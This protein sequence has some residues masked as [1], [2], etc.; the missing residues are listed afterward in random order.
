ML[1]LVLFTKLGLIRIPFLSSRGAQLFF[2][3]FPRT[4][5]CRISVQNFDSILQRLHT[6]PPRSLLPCPNVR[7]IRIRRKPYV[8]ELTTN[9][10]GEKPVASFPSGIYRVFNL[11]YM[12]RRLI[13][14]FLAPIRRYLDERLHR[15]PS[16]M[17]YHTFMNN[18]LIE[19]QKY[20]LYQ[21]HSPSY[22]Q[23]S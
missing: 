21:K 14:V 4:A 20:V 11:I 9:P 3:V 12:Y 17:N 8:K 13:S 16:R 23:V 5:C 15:T 1:N 2:S 10:Q 19:V 7:I 18:F 22:F 6:F